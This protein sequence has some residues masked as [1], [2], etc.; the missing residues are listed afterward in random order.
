[1]STETVVASRHISCHFISVRC[2][3]SD[4]VSW[5]PGVL[6]QLWLD[7]SVRCPHQN[8][9]TKV[10][11]NQEWLQLLGK[12]RKR[13]VMVRPCD[14]WSSRLMEDWARRDT[15]DIPTD[16]PQTYHRHTDQVF[17]DQVSRI[18]VSCTLSQTALDASRASTL[19]RTIENP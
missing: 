19:M 10:H 7:V 17:G 15:T 1:M 4:V 9:A 12:R 8:V 13:S 14:C 3:I 6:Q 11:R 5:F 18:L 16:I 2:A